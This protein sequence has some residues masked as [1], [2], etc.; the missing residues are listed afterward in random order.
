[1][2]TTHNLTDDLTLDELKKLHDKAWSH[3]TVTRERAADDLVFYWVTQWDDNML[4]ETQLQFR[5]EFNILRKAGRQI[6]ADLTSNPVQID[7][8][9]KSDKR[10]DGADLLDG[11]YLS[12]D[13]NNTSIE[14]Y[15]N[16]STE[17]VVCGVGAWEL[18]TKYVSNKTGDKN[19]VIR[20]RPIREANN[21]LFWDPNANLLDKSDADYCSL[22]TGYSEDGHKKLVKD[23]TGEDIDTSYPSFKHPEISYAFPW[24]GSE[25]KRIYVVTF[26]HRKL[27]KDKILTLDDPFG[28]RLMLRES[29]LIEVM[30][31][32]IEEGYTITDEKKIERYQVTKYIADGAKILDESVIA[33]EHIPVIP[34][35]GERAFVEDEEH[36]EGVTRL[37]KDPQRLRNFVLSYIADI[38]SRSPRPK[39]IFFPE[40]IKG[41]EAHYEENG[42]DNNYPYLLQNRLTPAGEPLPIGPVAQ[43]PEQPIPTSLLSL[44]ELTRQAVEDVANPGLPQNIADP[45][46]SGKAILALEARL[47][48]QSIVYQ[49]NLKHAKRR[50]G[51]VYASMAS[52]VYDSSRT[53]TLTMQDGSRKKDMIMQSVLD[54]DTGEMVV[55]NDITNMEFDVYA[56]IGPSYASKKDQTIEQLSRMAEA[57]AATDPNMQKALIM[58]QLTLID[59]VNMDDI[60]EYANKQLILNGFRQPETDEEKQLL[61]QSQQNQQPDAAMALAMAEQSK[62][63]AQAAKVQSDTQIA[64]FTAEN[65]QM[66]TQIDQYRA[67]TD[68]MNVQV[69]AEKANADISIKSFDSQTKRLSAQHQSARQLIGARVNDQQRASSVG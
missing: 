24:L 2:T 48:Q 32:L 16:A 17:S 55:L 33:G 57:V 35:Y 41:F 59:G 43:M 25:D 7:F 64:A 51:E 4:G 13:R 68:R 30:D 12:D 42:A 58:K 3:G 69:N 67:Q 39:P 62:A 53:V 63:D 38:G 5:G 49:Q 15:N 36:Y 50:D 45:D 40:Q 14:S 10:T 1:M 18:Y 22:L 44:T 23:L 21:T 26:Y 8:D 56:D 31:D 27:V 52:Q 54:K 19:Q 29:D 46:L 61:E 20:R 66:Q 60:R 28:Q 65:A 6:M 9:P 34:V 47:D 37:A 11:L